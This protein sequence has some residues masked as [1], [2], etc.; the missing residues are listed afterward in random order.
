VLRG[1]SARAVC[2]GS[3]FYTE[4]PKCKIKLLTITIHTLEPESCSRY[5]ASAMGWRVRGSSLDRA[6]DFSL[7]IIVHTD[8]KTDTFSCSLE[9]GVIS[10]SV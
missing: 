4:L 5:S 7:Q 8:Y 2:I 9:K 1:T 10:P 6:R 3:N